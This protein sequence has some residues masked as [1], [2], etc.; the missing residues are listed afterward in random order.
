MPRRHCCRHR[1]LQQSIPKRHSPR[2][3]R[4]VGRNRATATM[5]RRHCCRH[6]RLQQSSRPPQRCT[7]RQLRTHVRKKLATTATS[8]LIRE[9]ATHRRHKPGRGQRK[10]TRKKRHR[11][12]PELCLHR[13]LQQRAKALFTPR[14]A[15]GSPDGRQEATN[16]SR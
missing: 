11:Y 12:L 6:R 16:G 3:N 5:P 14:P 10:S 8:V 4:R 7:H 13:Q 15:Q 2:Q 1:R 9:V